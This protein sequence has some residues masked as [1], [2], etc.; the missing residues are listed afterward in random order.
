MSC[1]PIKVEEILHVD[2]SVNITFKCFWIHQSSFG[3]QET[4]IKN[5]SHQ[6]FKII[7]REINHQRIII[8]RIKIIN[9]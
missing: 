2:F 7:S 4:Y 8:L 5:I 1:L 9:L 6:F 3:T